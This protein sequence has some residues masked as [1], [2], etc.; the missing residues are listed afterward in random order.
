MIFIK[1]NHNSSRLKTDK[2]LKKIMIIYKIIV[3][4]LFHVDE[5]I[6]IHF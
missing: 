2:F 1:D 4:L 5:W 6:N 3:K